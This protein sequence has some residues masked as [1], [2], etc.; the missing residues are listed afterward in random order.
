MQQQ[1]LYIGVEYTLDKD[2]VFDY[3]VLSS[4]YAALTKQSMH[5][6]EVSASVKAA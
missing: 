2:L 3:F 6:L 1:M 4:D 5:R